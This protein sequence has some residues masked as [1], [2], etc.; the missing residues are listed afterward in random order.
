MHILLVFNRYRRNTHLAINL[1]K[2]TIQM[3]HI[4]IQ[5]FFMKLCIYEIIYICMRILYVYIVNL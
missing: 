1:Y 3:E 2:D 4:F 5:E